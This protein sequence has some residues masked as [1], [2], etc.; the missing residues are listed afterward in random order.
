M[1]RTVK[2]HKFIL[3]ALL[4][5]AMSVSCG[6]NDNITKKSEVYETSNAAEVTDNTLTEHVTFPSP[7]YHPS[8][9]KH[10]FFEISDDIYDASKKGKRL[11]IYFYQDGCPYCKKLIE[12]NLGQDDI[13]DYARNNFDIIAINIFGSVDV[14]DTDGEVL[15]EKEFAKKHNINF[16]P[17]MLTYNEEGDV[18]FRMNGYYAQ[19]KFMA[20]LKYLAEKQEDNIKFLDFL[21]NYLSQNMPNLLDLKNYSKK[22]LVPPFNLS[23]S[24]QSESK[25]LVVFFEEAN[26]AACKELHEDT[27]QRKE[28]KT[29]LNKFTLAIIDVNSDIEM[30]SPLG[31]KTSTNAW[32]KKKEVQFIPTVI[33]FNKNGIEVFRIDGYVKEFHLNSSFEY[34]LTES[35]KTYDGFQPFLHDRANRLEEKGIKIEIMK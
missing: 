7:T 26:C 9:F 32:A 29:F 5:T 12:H 13:S 30:V 10:S 18:I 35:Y 17:T 34:V 20:M 25:P 8:W 24:I 21:D 31:E 4:I 28:T 6:Q 14:T 27:L 19:D 16:T 1:A 2:I 33:F 23:K 3:T 15:S 22:F 11:I